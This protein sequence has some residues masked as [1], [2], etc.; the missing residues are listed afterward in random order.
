MKVYVLFAGM[1]DECGIDSVHSNEESLYARVDLM[2]NYDRI[3]TWELFDKL[4]EK[5]FAW[6]V[7]WTANGVGIHRDDSGQRG[8]IPKFPYDAENDRAYVWAATEYDALV[9]AMR[10][11]TS[12]RNA[13]P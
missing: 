2:K 11:R 3:E 7:T 5:S 6:I 12:A 9:Y 1:H 8:R 13:R 4:P 10:E